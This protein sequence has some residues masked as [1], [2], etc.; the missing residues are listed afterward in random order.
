MA[1]SEHGECP[2]ECEDTP[3]PVADQTTCDAAELRFRRIGA[4]GACRPY[5]AMTTANW[6]RLKITTTM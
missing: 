1:D 3:A 2:A 6:A 4:P 5:A